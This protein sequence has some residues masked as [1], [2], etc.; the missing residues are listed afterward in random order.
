MSKVNGIERHLIEKILDTT[1]D[2]RR[3]YLYYFLCLLWETYSKEEVKL[4]VDHLL[5]QNLVGI[6]LA[7]KLHFEYK[8]K[9]EEFID[10]FNIKGVHRQPSFLKSLFQATLQVLDVISD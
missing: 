2:K 6:N 4:I 9:Y 1:T 7:I 10:S 5:S 3:N 8:D